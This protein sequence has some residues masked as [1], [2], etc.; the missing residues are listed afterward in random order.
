[1]KI[2]RKDGSEG[3][4]LVAGGAIEWDGKKS[5]MAFAL[6]ITDSKILELKL[7][8]KEELFRNIFNYSSAGQYILVNGKAHPQNNL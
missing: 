6:D 8:E 3:W 7:K 1:M 5:V 4:T 2:L